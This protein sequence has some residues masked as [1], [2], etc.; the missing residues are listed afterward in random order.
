MYG[1]DNQLNKGEKGENILDRYYSKWYSITPVSMSSQKAGMDR[2][3]EERTT[4]MRTSVEYKTDEWTPKSGRV[5]IETVSVD[6]VG[7]KGWAYTSLAQWLIY[8]VPG[9]RRA[10]RITML[11]I[12][13]YLPY[14]I[15]RIG[16]VPG[17]E[18]KKVKNNGYFTEGI[19][20]PLSEFA[21][22]CNKID[23]DI[24]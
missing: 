13:H 1:F 9:F 8:Y 10:Y 18:Y 3:W 14:W 19:V 16:K 5:F 7:K 17:Y 6:T 24:E 21:K 2:V 23:E 4:G 22:R 11:N 20:I 15:E 12:K